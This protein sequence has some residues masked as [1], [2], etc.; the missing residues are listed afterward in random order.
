MFKVTYDR[1]GEN[2]VF[3]PFVDGSTVSQFVAELG[4]RPEIWVD[5]DSH[6]GVQYA[7]GQW[8]TEVV[9]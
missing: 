7:N 9:R 2:E 4:G 1:G 5:N 6:V 8:K 3:G